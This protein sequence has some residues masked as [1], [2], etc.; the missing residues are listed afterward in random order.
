MFL[1]TADAVPIP[2]RAASSAYQCGPA[3]A[4]PPTAQVPRARGSD[5][6]GAFLLCGR[7]MTAA[8]VWRV[9]LASALL[10]ACTANT[11]R[12]PQFTAKKAPP[13]TVATT[14]VKCLAKEH[15]STEVV[16]DAFSA[17]IASK[18][19]PVDLPAEVRVQLCGE[20]ATDAAVST[21]SSDW[22]LGKTIASP[23]TQAMAKAKAAGSVLVP[24]VRTNDECGDT[25]CV[26][27]SVDVGLFLFSADGVLLWKGAAHQSATGDGVSKATATELAKALVAEIPADL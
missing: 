21:W 7:T 17:E 27:K 9:L 5:I 2:S 15:R 24:I 8:M 22:D 19:K 3:R 12:S 18:T 14:L 4:P 10:C 25:G 6:S 1:E 26:E 13:P 16:S 20:L 23:M 11:F